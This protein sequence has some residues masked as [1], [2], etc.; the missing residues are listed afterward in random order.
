M[1]PG[2]PCISRITAFFKDALMSV[3]CS[4]GY[5]LPESSASVAP[6]LPGVSLATRLPSTLARKPFAL[7]G[8]LIDPLLSMEAPASPHSPQESMAKGVLQFE[9]SVGY[10]VSFQ[11]TR[12]TV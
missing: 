4:L 8:L 10:L 5:W 1:F 3:I 2:C 7:P 12:T 9:T 6:W 11:A